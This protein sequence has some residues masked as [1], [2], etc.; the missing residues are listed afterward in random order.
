MENKARWDNR[1]TG[2]LFKLGSPG[3]WG[4]IQF[5]HFKWILITRKK[6]KSEHC[7]VQRISIF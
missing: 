5:K 7:R 6:K 2:G 4:K 3:L 1:V